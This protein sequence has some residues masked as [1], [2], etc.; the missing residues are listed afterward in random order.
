MDNKEKSVGVPTKREQEFLDLYMQ[1]LSAEEIADKMCISIK[2]VRIYTY[3]LKQKGLISPNRRLYLKVPRH[4]ARTENEQNIQHFIDEYNELFDVSPHIKFVTPD[5]I[6]SVIGMLGFRKNDVNLLIR[7]Y[8]E[9]HLYE[10]AIGLLYDYEKNNMLLKHEH[11]RVSA[12]KQRLRHE[13]L[14]KL[15]ADVPNALIDNAKKTIGEP[16]R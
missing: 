7:I 11:E 13:M 10:D 9:R 5:Q 14:S 16:E 2:S 12:L 1:H 4:R 8:A 3:R 15:H 6:R